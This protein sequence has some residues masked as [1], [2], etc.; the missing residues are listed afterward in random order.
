MHRQQSSVAL[1]QQKLAEMGSYSKYYKAIT[2]NPFQVKI[3]C[4]CGRSRNMAWMFLCT[5]CATG[6]EDDKDTAE[7]PKVTADSDSKDDDAATT[8]KTVS[9][10]VTSSSTES[11]AVRPQRAFL[12]CDLCA[13][14]MTES[15]YC[16]HC[17]AAYPAH[18]VKL[19]TRCTR[20][21]M[22]PVC[23]SPLEKIVYAGVSTS[24]SSTG[25]G[26]A[27]K[28]KKDVYMY[29]C[30]FC[31]W[32]SNIV[33][34]EASESE[35]LLENL[36]EKL[37]RPVEEKTMLMKDIKDKYQELNE[38]LRKEEDRIEKAKRFHIHK[39][40]KS[41]LNT[42]AHH[43]PTS[44]DHSATGMAKKG[45][46]RGSSK[47]GT[48]LGSGSG[49]GVEWMAQIEAQQAAQF[50]KLHVLPKEKCTNLEPPLDGK[51]V[52]QFH[53]RN[54]SPLQHRLSWPLLQAME[55]EKYVPQKF[56]LMTKESYKCPNGK[57]AKYVC[58][59]TLRGRQANYDKRTAVLDY[60]P[61]VALEV[62][63]GSLM[64]TEESTVCVMLQNR[65][66]HEAQIRF[67]AAVNDEDLY[68]TAKIECSSE[69]FTIDRADIHI[70]GG[71]Q[72]DEKRENGDY[73][74]GKEAGILVTVTP[75]HYS[76][77]PR[78]VKF[79]IRCTFKTKL[80]LK[81]DQKDGNHKSSNDDKNKKSGKQ[82]Q[83]LCE[84]QMP[85]ILDFDLG[86][87]KT[88]KTPDL[89]RMPLSALLSLSRM[90]LPRLR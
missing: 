58:K 54:V 64:T 46:P 86:P 11:G 43:T 74:K 32:S 9:A 76:T 6:T 70:M 87:P 79:S 71:P 45:R 30:P 20:C 33:N 44:S 22:C 56:H 66:L 35:A 38:N 8:E 57:C 50:K 77:G 23:T 21:V 75:K 84:V 63:A 29:Q 36:K 24:S 15:Y 82:Q 10:D 3:R 5:W 1:L 60:L 69:W 18:Y 28:K 53:L 90:L 17:L 19:R 2:S 62:V 80:Q 49:G 51:F 72:R 31:F 39:G 12:S 13:S 81:E 26:S 88:A 73:V 25:D 34:L 37:K 78:D 83:P 42:T 59:P 67:D 16:P 65:H 47:A 61:R 27:G 89:T 40:G 48:G 7:K 4:Q 85:Y 68:S 55:M 41:L 14:K 52:A